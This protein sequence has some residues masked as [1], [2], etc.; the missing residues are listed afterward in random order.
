ME[1][2]TDQNNS[3]FITGHKQNEFHSIS[4]INCTCWMVSDIH[5]REIAEQILLQEEKDAVLLKGSRA[6]TFLMEGNESRL[7]MITTSIPKG[8]HSMVEL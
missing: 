1:K 6:R 7:E 3:T 2:K 8:K 5:S 4:Q